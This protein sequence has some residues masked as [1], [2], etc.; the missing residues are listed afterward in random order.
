MYSPRIQDDLIPV[1][2]RLA[3]Q[4][5]KPMTRLVDEILRAEIESRRSQGDPHSDSDILRKPKKNS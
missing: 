1:L 4:E 2:Y 3:Q 5:G